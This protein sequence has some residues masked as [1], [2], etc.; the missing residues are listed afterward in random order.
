MHIS[1]PVNKRGTRLRQISFVTVKLGKQTAGKNPAP[2]V[3]LHA[4]PDQNTRILADVKFIKQSSDI[5]VY[6][7]P[8]L[9]LASEASHY[10]LSFG[11]AEHS[12]QFADQGSGMARYNW[13][14]SGTEEVWHISVATVH[15]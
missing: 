12:F 4:G 1:A 13:V 11:G 5:T 9:G 3:S 6:H 7:T 2:A 14:H 8:T 15:R 10:K